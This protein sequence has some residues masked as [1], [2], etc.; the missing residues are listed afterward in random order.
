MITLEDIK[1]L[2]PCPIC[3]NSGPTF[4]HYA[5]AYRVTCGRYNCDLKY[6]IIAPSKE[7]AIS[8]WNDS[9]YKED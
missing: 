9:N 8:A 3:G 6:C 2:K 7:A 4:Y 1:Q 5:G